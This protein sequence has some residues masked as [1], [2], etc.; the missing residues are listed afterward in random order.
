MELVGVDLCGL[1]MDKRKEIVA[2]LLFV[3]VEEMYEDIMV[4]LKA[5]YVRL[6]KRTL[7]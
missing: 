1:Q 6:F 5:L 2:L 4:Q 3:L 7:R